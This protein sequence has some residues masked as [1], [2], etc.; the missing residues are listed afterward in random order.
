MLAPPRP[1]ANPEALIPE[2]R[3]RQRRRRVVV[4]AI[5]AAA[6]GSVLGVYA[7]VGARERPRTTVTPR[8]PSPGAFC[9]TS[10]L[11][12]SM[13]WPTGPTTGGWVVLWNTSDSACALPLGVP[14]AW[15]TWN[16]KRLPT[17][18]EHR[19][20]IRPADWMP[21]QTARTLRPGRK[22]GVTFAWLN[23]CGTPRS[24]M[25]LMTGHLRF[26]A[27]NL[28]FRAGSHPPCQSPG[29]ASVLQVSRLLRVRG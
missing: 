24:Y 3:D 1:P 19:L 17:R 21:L 11:S 25:P 10:Q 23:W 12:A 4:A 5:I 28:S 13:E 20:G 7:L 16:G 14:H 29:T 2:A 6:A 26:G 18:E 27:A 8:P 15:I 22:A 9:R